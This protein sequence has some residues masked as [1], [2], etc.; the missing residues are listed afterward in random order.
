LGHPGEQLPGSRLLPPG[1]GD[2]IEVAAFS[3]AP[4][5]RIHTL[6]LFRYSFIVNEGA[7]LEERV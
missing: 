6:W 7:L 3:Q 5:D 4:T 1:I 2:Y